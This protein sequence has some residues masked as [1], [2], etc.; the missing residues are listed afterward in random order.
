MSAVPRSSQRLARLVDGA[1]GELRLPVGETDGIRVVQTP[2]QAPNAN[3]YAE[4]FVRSI[5]EEGLS[6]V[7]PIGERHLRRTIAGFVEHYHGERNHQGL[8][9]EL[10]AGAPPVEGGRQTRRRQRLGGLLII[11][12]ARRD[13][14][15]GSESIARLND[16]T[17]RVRIVPSDATRL[18]LFL[19]RHGK[20]AAIQLAA[21]AGR[22][23][24]STSP[25][26]A[27][28]RAGKVVGSRDAVVGKTPAE[29]E[30]RCRPLHSRRRS[31]A[32][33]GLYVG[34]DRTEAC[35]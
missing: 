27:V 11:T 21:P 35:A 34:G 12:V 24:K 13:E 10:I 23:G 16:G 1:P 20:D 29:R 22:Q 15:R 28:E 8:D 31:A 5:K 3:A 33:V 32:A 2:F 4:R 26:V 25:N 30:T 14:T 17:L 6:R 9:N 18:L 19:Q 7:I